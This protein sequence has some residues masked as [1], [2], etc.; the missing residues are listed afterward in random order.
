MNEIRY[1]LR[2]GVNRLQSPT[3]YT[4]DIPVEEARRLHDARGIYA[5]VVLR[6]KVPFAFIEAND[7][8]FGVSFIDALGR[9][10][11]NYAFRERE[12]GRLFLEQ[13][14]FRNFTDDTPRATSQE[15]Y[16]FDVDGTHSERVSDFVNKTVKTSEP[17]VIDVSGN[18]APYP[19]FGEYDALLRIER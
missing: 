4:H 15:I 18:W 14:S 3:P 7:G 1:Y 2:W 12:P 6:E 17:R 10:F 11:L 8:F 5:A 9:V 19:V 13:A 16:L